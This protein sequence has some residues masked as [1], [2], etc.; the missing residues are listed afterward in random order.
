MSAG[1]QQLVTRCP[2]GFGSLCERSRAVLL[3]REAL[4]L[5]IAFKS[6]RL[7]QPAWFAPPLR[8]VLGAGISH[9]IETTRKRAESVNQHKRVII[10]RTVQ[11]LKKIRGA[12]CLG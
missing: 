4:A 7:G 11:S 10:D 3:A 8:A 9:K 12:L 6:T 5:P 2:I 1:L